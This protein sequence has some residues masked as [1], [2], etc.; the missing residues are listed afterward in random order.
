MWKHLAHQKTLRLEKLKFWYIFHWRIFSNKDK[1]SIQ[2]KPSFICLFYSWIRGDCPT[3]GGFVEVIAHVIMIE[4]GRIS[5]SNVRSSKS[6]NNHWLEIQS[7]LDLC[8]H[9]GSQIWVYKWRFFSII[10]LNENWRWKTKL[11]LQEYKKYIIRILPW[12]RIPEPLSTNEKIHGANLKS[13]GTVAS[14][15]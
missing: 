1:C 15:R 2:F 12:V 14:T 13:N 9:F 10:R 7:G 4:I 6:C 3:G 11:W 8:L 5:T